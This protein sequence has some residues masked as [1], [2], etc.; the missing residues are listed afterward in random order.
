M[1]T[2]PEFPDPELDRVAQLLHKVEAG[3]ASDEEREELALYEASPGALAKA[4]EHQLSE[5]WLARVDADH[6]IDAIERS[7][8]TRFER[9]GGVA[10]LLGGY[11]LTFV[12]PVAGMT[13]AGLGA[14]TLVLS[15]IRTKLLTLGKDPYRDVER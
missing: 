6:Q 3:H 2:P 4:R 13:L 1:S 11:A 5:G 12:A 8:L 10:A 7:T 9:G 14:L 15:F